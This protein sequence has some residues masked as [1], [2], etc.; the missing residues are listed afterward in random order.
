MIQ[1][2]GITYTNNCYY[3]A[4]K[5]YIFFLQVTETQAWERI[6]F[7]K[8]AKQDSKKAIL[9]IKLYKLFK[10]KEAYLFAVTHIKYN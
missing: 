8:K 9:E 7:C 6:W 1:I 10:I 3:I 5:V 4:V 2:S